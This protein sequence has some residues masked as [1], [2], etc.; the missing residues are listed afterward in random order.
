MESLLKAPGLTHNEENPWIRKHIGPIQE[1]YSF[2]KHR[3]INKASDL[4][5]LA[6][7]EFDYSGDILYDISSGF[8]SEH[9]FHQM[10]MVERK[11]GERSQ[12]PFLLMV[13]NVGYLLM[14]NNSKKN[15][16]KIFSSVDAS[17]RDIDIKGW[18]RRDSLVG[19]VFIE[20]DSEK[21]DHLR[22][23]VKNG[24]AREFSTEVADSL[25]II[26][27]VCHPPKRAEALASDTTGTGRYETLGSRAQF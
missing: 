22:A 4:N 16:K 24:F 23:K 10:F 19:I 8:Y 15:I 13:I 12:S 2:L 3:L 26:A 14:G 21:I 17:T 27:Q 25:S 5:D 6:E 11:R 20:S 18:Y 7:K 1:S 9:Y